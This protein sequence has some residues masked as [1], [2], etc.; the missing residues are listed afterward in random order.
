MIGLALS[1]ALSITGILSGVVNAFS[2][3]ER[4]MVAVERVG[5]YIDEVEIEPEGD[6]LLPPFGWPSQGVVEFRNV[7][8]RYRHVYIYFTDKVFASNNKLIE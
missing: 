7:E 1:Y 5:Q 6:I 3:T 4:E 8:L 2:E